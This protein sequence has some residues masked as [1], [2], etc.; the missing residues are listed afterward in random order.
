MKFL[1]P[2]VEGARLA[3]WASSHSRP[4]AAYVGGWLGH[5]NLGDE[6]LFDACKVLFSGVSLYPLNVCRETVAMARLTRAF[7][8][9]MLAGGTIINK[10]NS[11]LMRAQRMLDIAKCCYVFGTGVADPAFWQGRT[12]RDGNPWSNSISQWRE[13]LEQCAYVGVRGPLSQRILMDAGV[14]K[15]EVIGDPV[16]AFADCSLG[17][18]GVEKTLGLNMGVSGGYMWGESEE[19]VFR[20]LTRLASLAKGDGWTVR[21]FVVWPEDYAVTESAA[22]ESGTDEHIHA[23]YMD[24]T[25]Y[26]HLVSK[27]RVFVGMKLHAVILATCAGVPSIML[28]YRPKCRDYM[29]SIR[30]GQLCQRVDQFKPEDILDRVRDIDG[31]REQCVADMATAISQLQAVQRLRAD[32]VMARIMTVSDQIA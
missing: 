9:A 19:S 6:A 16:L 18:R 26:L 2:L 32:Q 5:N 13:V 28:E 24:H 29:E 7:H 3:L 11:G 30:Q 1:T 27:T 25:R 22:K 4:R 21:W 8:C 31:N 12:L 20:R 10:N 14:R 23:V 15:P 17:R